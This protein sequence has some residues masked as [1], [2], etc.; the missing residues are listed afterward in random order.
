[1]LRVFWL[2][3]VEFPH[4]QTFLCHQPV[5]RFTFFLKSSCRSMT[6]R[7]EGWT[8]PSIPCFIV[9]INPKGTVSILYVDKNENRQIPLWVWL[10]VPIFSSWAGFSFNLMTASVWQ[11]HP[12]FFPPFPRTPLLVW[13]L[14]HNVKHFLSWT[15][16]KE[17]EDYLIFMSIAWV[18]DNLCPVKSTYTWK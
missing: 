7:K 14:L 9:P 5:L 4:F 10:F 15:F 11:D 13:M 8:K 18:T 16:A 1:M 17:K 6:L 2:W 12:C 3:S